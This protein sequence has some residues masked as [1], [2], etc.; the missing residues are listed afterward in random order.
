MCVVH[1]VDR[2]CHEEMLRAK[3]EDL[4][5]AVEERDQLKDNLKSIESKLKGKN[6]VSHL[7]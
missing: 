2:T 1:Q 7:C 5:R 3:E 4:A 6:N